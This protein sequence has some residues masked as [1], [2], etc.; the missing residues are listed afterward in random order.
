LLISRPRAPP[1]PHPFPTPRSSD[2]ILWRVFHAPASGG[3][4][5]C[6]IKSAAGEL[7]LRAS[8]AKEYFGLIYIGD[9]NDF[10]K[11]VE[12]DDAGITRSEEH[13]SEL[14]SRENL[15]CRLPLEK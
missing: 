3:L 10:K 8:G 1:S 15:V 13:T 6:D 11:L 9:T 4:H 2:L 7:G 14:Q 5:L 12:T